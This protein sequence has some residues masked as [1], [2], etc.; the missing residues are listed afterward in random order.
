VVVVDVFICD[1]WIGRMRVIFFRGHSCSPAELRS[2]G[3]DGNL[4]ANRGVDSGGVIVLLQA[5][6]YLSGVDSNY[7]VISRSIV[8]VSLKHFDSN[9]P[10]LQ[11][12][13]VSSKAVAN[14]IGE[15]LLAA[16]AGT[17][18]PAL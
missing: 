17:K 18:W 16:D 4:D 8:R 9:G 15:E 3:A 13:E 12:L 5:S 6:A 10:F 2:I 1:L 11:I 14:D 7:R